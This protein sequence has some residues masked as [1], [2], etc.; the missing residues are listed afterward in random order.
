MVSRIIHTGHEKQEHL[1]SV[2]VS[3]GSFVRF[4]P[5]RQ[6]DLGSKFQDRTSK[7]TTRSDTKAQMLYLSYRTDIVRVAVQASTMKKL[8][9]SIPS[10]PLTSFHFSSFSVIV[11]KKGIKSWNCLTWN[12][13]KLFLLLLHLQVSPLKLRLNRNPILR[14]RLP[15]LYL[16]IPDN[17]KLKN[18]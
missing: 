10:F 18:P 14:V 11:N 5:S 12:N 6:S 1:E 7:W 15:N 9:Q 17:F 3:S 13:T 2:V 8:N 4:P 16:F